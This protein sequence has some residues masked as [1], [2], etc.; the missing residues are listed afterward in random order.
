MIPSLG[1]EVPQQGGSDPE[2]PCL[3]SPL[4]QRQ[5][6]RQPEAT[7]RTTAECLS[8]YERYLERVVGIVAATREKYLAFAKRFLTTQFES[9]ALPDWSSLDGTAISEF[10]RREAQQT[11]ITH[12]ARRRQRSGPCYAMLPAHLEAAVPLRHEWR[13][14]SLPRML[15]DEEVAR[16]INTCNQ[17]TSIGLRNRAILVL[18]SR[19]GL[20]AN[21][22]PN[23]VW[24]TSTGLRGGC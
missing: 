19:L 21:R 12:V 1:S 9:D 16:L 4:Q 18:L 10:V 2:K 17:E 5:P 23:S 11:A 8:D 3:V 15:S 22:W 14:A 13:L 6:Q 7:L 24:M 20:R